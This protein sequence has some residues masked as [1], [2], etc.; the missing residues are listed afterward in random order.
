VWKGKNVRNLFSQIGPLAVSFMIFPFVLFFCLARIS[1]ISIFYG[2][3]GL[4]NGWGLD[5]LC[6]FLFGLGFYRS[7]RELNSA[8]SPYFLPL[9]L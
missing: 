8:F 1:L 5:L 4:L 3:S 6:P 9:F 2:F 7:G